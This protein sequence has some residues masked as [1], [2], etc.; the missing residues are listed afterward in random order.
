[1]KKGKERSDLGLLLGRW[2]LTI[3]VSLSE[4]WA[5]S[6]G[7]V[8]RPD[9]GNVLSITLHYEIGISIY[10]ESSLTLMEVLNKQF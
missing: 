5:L 2:K 1:M 9:N 10:A 6:R 4:S 3:R 8:A 7:N